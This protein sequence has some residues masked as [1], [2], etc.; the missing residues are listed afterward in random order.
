MTVYLTR[1]E[2]FNAAHQLWV[3]DWSDEKNFEVFGKCA[4][5]NFHG[6]NYDLFIT[7][8]GAPNPVTGFIMDAKKLSKIIKRE[9]TN[10]LDHTNMNL[11]E[12][13][14]PKGVLPTTENLVVYIWKQ[15]ADHLDEG[16]FL[17]SVK[18]EETRNIWAEYF[19][20]E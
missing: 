6:H 13:F 17:H 9:V 2:S 16:C 15:L 12:N 3:A 7:V 10:V 5:K 20:E 1:R 11:D 8:K 14:L 4:N 19:G 18:L